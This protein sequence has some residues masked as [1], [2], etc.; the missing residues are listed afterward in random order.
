[1]GS[2]VAC[3]CDDD[4]DDSSGGDTEPDDD[5]A[6]DDDLDDDADDD[7]AAD[8]DV[9]DD[10]SDDDTGD[11]DA[12]DDDDTD[13][14]DPIAATPGYVDRCEE[15]LQYCF[16]NQGPG[17]GG[18]HGQVCRVAVG[19]EIY[20]DP[21]QANLTKADNR[22]DTAD[23]GMTSIMRLLYLGQD[24]AYLTD[25]LKADIEET[26]LDFKYWPDEGGSDHM[27]FWSENHQILF[28]SL[29]LLAGQYFRGETFTND[30][31]TGQDHIDKAIPRL[32]A[33]FEMRARFGFTEFHSNV[34]YNED[35]PALLNLVDFAEDEEIREKAEMALDL[36]AFDMAVNSFKGY[37]ATAHGRTYPGSVM[38]RQGESTRTIEWIL[39]GQ[40]AYTS[41]GHFTGVGLC[42]SSYAPPAVLEAIA[43]DDADP[44]ESRQRDGFWIDDGP[45]YGIGYTDFEDVMFWWSASAYAAWQVMPGAL[46][47][48]EDYNLWD[49]YWGALE[50]LRPLIGTAF[51]EETLKALDPMSRG[52]ATEEANLY[53]YRTADY[54]LSSVQD[55][56]PGMWAGQQ[57]MWTAILDGDAVVFTTYPGGMPGDYLA[58]D[59]NGGW[60]PRAGQYRNVLVAIYLKPSIPLLDDL[61]F[62][63]YTHAYFPKAAFDETH[64]ETHW[65]FGR[66]GDAYLA[67]YSDVEPAWAD[68][69]A[70]GYEL[71]ADNPSNVWILE[72]GRASDDGTFQDFID[73]LL[74]ASLSVDGLDVS[75]DSP[76]VGLVE[77]GWTGPLVVGGDAVDQG[78]YPRFDNAYA[79]QAWDTN[80]YVIAF[81]GMTLKLDFEKPWRRFWESDG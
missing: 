62:K 65:T 19:G 64:E 6:G 69:P 27:I 51:V 60:T 41:S 26:L 10:S 57:H 70:D 7:T 63:D 53:T 3:G 79:Q 56:K 77:Y 78:P 14:G 30:G 32:H 37:F 66:L 75:Y 2:L 12:A 4:D 47:V 80:P 55:Y 81:D 18:T 50:I 11:D 73:G 36:F 38:G 24:S 15:Y 22:E 25:D 68:P 54:Q 21:I 42:T 40:G 67:L 76:S 35:M 31:L 61:L 58:T 52:P 34:Y 48:M 59:W 46:Q 16:D 29:E 8:D 20:E 74:A 17:S 23:F 13:P 49:G 28:L 5:S 71:I 72:L 39:F 1:M 44:I 33:W 45:S 43:N 9:D